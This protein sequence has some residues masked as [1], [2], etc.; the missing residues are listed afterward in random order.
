MEASLSF[1]RRNER[2]QQAKLIKES[3][4]RFDDYLDLNEES[5]RRSCKRLMSHLYAN[6]DLRAP[7]TE[8]S[9]LRGSPLPRPASLEFEYNNK[10]DDQSSVH[11]EEHERAPK[12]ISSKHSDAKRS[13]F[14]PK[15]MSYLRLQYEKR[16]QRQTNQANKMQQSEPSLS[17]QSMERHS[18]P[19]E[20]ATDASLGANHRLLQQDIVAR[21]HELSK[22]RFFERLEQ[23]ELLKSASSSDST[24]SNSSQIQISKALPL[25]SRTQVISA[26]I[27]S[28]KSKIQTKSYK[29]GAVKNSS[30]NQMKWATQRTASTSTEVSHKSGPFEQS[31]FKLEHV[32]VGIE[33]IGLPSTLA[34]KSNL[35]EFSNDTQWMANSSSDQSE[36]EIQVPANLDCSLFSADS[37]DRNSHYEQMRNSSLL[38][39]KQVDSIESGCCIKEKE[40]GLKAQMSSSASMMENKETLICADKH[41][42]SKLITDDK[43]R[44]SVARRQSSSIS[45]LEKQ[46]MT[47]GCLKTTI[48]EGTVEI[49]QDFRES[50]TVADCPRLDQK[51]KPTGGEIKSIISSPRDDNLTIEPRRTQ[52]ASLFELKSTETTGESV[53]DSNLN[54]AL[55]LASSLSSLKDSKDLLVEIANAR[56]N[57]ANESRLP[58]TR[59]PVVQSLGGRSDLAKSNEFSVPLVCITDQGYK[60]EHVNENIA[61]GSSQTKKVAGLLDLVSLEKSVVNFKIRDY[62]PE[63]DEI[64]RTCSRALVSEDCQ[65]KH[66]GMPTEAREYK[67]QQVNKANKNKSL[68]ESIDEKT[69]N[70]RIHEFKNPSKEQENIALVSVNHDEAAP[71]DDALKCQISESGP[72]KKCNPIE[73]SSE[74]TKRDHQGILTVGQEDDGGSSCSS[75]GFGAS[76]SDGCASGSQMLNDR[77]R[78]EM[79]K[80]CRPC[81]NMS[82]GQS[83]NSLVTSS[84][85]YSVCESGTDYATY[86]K[87]A[88]S[89]S[90][91][92][93]SATIMVENQNYTSV[94]KRGYFNQLLEQDS[95]R[96]QGQLGSAV[97]VNLRNHGNNLILHQNGYASTGSI[98][99]VSDDT[100]QMIEKKNGSEGELSNRSYQ[101]SDSANS[102]GFSALPPAH[103]NHLLPSNNFDASISSLN[104]AGSQKK[105]SILK[106]FGSLVSRAFGPN[107]ATNEESAICS[108]LASLSLEKRGPETMSTTYERLDKFQKVLANSSDKVDSTQDGQHVLRD[109]KNDKCEEKMMFKEADLVVITSDCI[110]Q[111]KHHMKTPRLVQRKNRNLAE[112]L[113]IHS[114]SR[115]RREAHCLSS[116]CSSLTSLMTCTSDNSSHDRGYIGRSRLRRA[117][118]LSDEFESLISKSSER[119]FVKKLRRSFRPKSGQRQSIRGQFHEIDCELPAKRNDHSDTQTRE[120]GEQGNSSKSVKG[121]LGSAYAVPKL[122]TLSSAMCLNKTATGFVGHDKA[123]KIIPE[124]HIYE[125]NL[126]KDPSSVRVPGLSNEQR[127]N[128]TITRPA[129]ALTRRSMDER[130]QERGQGNHRCHHRNKHPHS[131]CHSNRCSGCRAKLRTAQYS[132]RCNRDMVKVNRKDVK[133]SVLGQVISFDESDG[134]QLIKLKRLN[135]NPWGFFVAKG[136]INNTK[137]K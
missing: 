2:R 122:I 133:G 51:K 20:P 47:V 113:Y 52:S 49:N 77:G 120:K 8:F 64:N 130:Y 56:S 117:D 110:K 71:K 72:E 111:R 30:P 37:L 23:R 1:R 70:N 19:N 136:V 85:R 69:F 34:L 5:L 39:V 35:I 82:S 91:R 84:D 16:Q 128:V 131:H 125:K 38:V 76:S 46:I 57:L 103:T 99:R 24:F 27:D 10:I 44:T 123:P 25:S 3:H 101:T 26:G 48:E 63:A 62:P 116:S 53:D 28:S 137:G 40:S 61:S 50:I 33:T 17:A 31:D 105:P 79:R 119:N 124:V 55:R 60:C 42:V 121:S 74:P 4:A 118:S 108:E 88:C 96:R 7:Q 18:I 65:G 15:S 90:N 89:G 6:N 59:S 92:P 73:L 45:E 97:Y 12:W 112:D 134:S 80:S 68:V 100:S 36:F 93:K 78:V 106:R 81:G 32:S 94:V 86:A 95:S 104:Q 87:P 114:R 13:T 21:S 41:R 135:E 132:S 58:E 54:S 126:K 98:N 115:S 129:H 29:S 66:F 109:H 43:A 102:G 107:L 22:R 75:S 14:D 67:Q 127:P 9:N 83:P 11:F